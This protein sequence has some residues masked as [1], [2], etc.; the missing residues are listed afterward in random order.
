MRHNRKW[1][2]KLLNKKNL[3]SKVVSLIWL[4]LDGK[5]RDQGYWSDNNQF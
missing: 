1:V 5:W 4:L 3:P 2:Y